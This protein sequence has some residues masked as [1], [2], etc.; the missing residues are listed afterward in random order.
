MQ[1]GRIDSLWWRYLCSISIG[2][3]CE[4]EPNWFTN[5][6]GCV[7]GNGENT[8]FWIDLWL[9]DQPLCEKFPALFNLAEDKD[10][11]GA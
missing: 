8:L 6:V 1:S 2:K 7:V 9:G 5:S 4:L 11:T 3:A 10:S